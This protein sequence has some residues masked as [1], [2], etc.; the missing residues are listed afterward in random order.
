MNL[1]ILFS[2]QGLQKPSHI[3]EILQQASPNEKAFIEQNLSELFTSH[4]SEN[5]Y[6]NKVAQPLIYCLQYYRWQQLYK[7]IDSPLALAGYSLGEACAFCVSCDFDF[8]QGFDFIQT[9]AN[10]MEKYPQNESGLLS[11]Q[12][13]TQNQLDT[14]LAETD[15]YLSIKISQDSFI[16]GGLQ[17]NLNQA[18]TLALATG[19]NNTQFLKVSIS[20]HTPLLHQASNDFLAY[21]ETLNTPKMQLPIISA[22]HG[23]RY[24][25]VKQG[26]E[27]LAQQIDY[28]LDW[29]IC[30]ETIKEYQPDV[31]VE[32]GPGNAL[33]RMM[34]NA[35]P[36]IPCRSYDDFKDIQG[37]E[38]WLCKQGF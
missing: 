28:A 18:N 12:G 38:A 21:V 37:L 30:M 20:S 8:Q 22:S 10:L 33:V 25:D 17:A 29:Y 1:V 5:L 31:I 3:E 27:I 13:L 7:I 24:N 16:I 15:T 35:L 9:R 4:A 26:G 19:A 23:I 14:L 32:I 6:Q 2:G 34:N 11:I 36:H